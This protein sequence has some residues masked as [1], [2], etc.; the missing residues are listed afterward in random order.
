MM[1]FMV[2]GNDVG[3]SMLSHFRE[4]GEACVIG[5]SIVHAERLAE[6][7][8]GCKLEL[9]GLRKSFM[10]WKSPSELLHQM[11]RCDGCQALA[12]S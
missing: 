11:T 9:E 12:F 10:A 6:L 7:A 5:D 8:G 1:D 3:L 2:N 4:Q